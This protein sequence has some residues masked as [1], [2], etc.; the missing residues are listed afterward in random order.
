MDNAYCGLMYAA[1]T[2]AETIR[3]LANDGIG[4]HP[5]SIGYHAQQLAEKML[6]AALD[7]RG[8]DF[9]YTHNIQVLLR[10]I[11][12]NGLVDEPPEDVVEA[13]LYLSGLISVTRYAEAPDF[14]EGEA[15]R[16]ILAANTIARFLSD[17][18]FDAIEVSIPESSNGDVN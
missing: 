2:D 13:A 12:H 11:Q 18:G 16:A 15:R 7:S 8:F 9:P 5:E 10:R 14:E 3:I 6:K 1:S 17:N 4:L